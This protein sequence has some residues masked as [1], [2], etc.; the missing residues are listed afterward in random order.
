MSES[1]V[2]RGKRGDSQVSIADVRQ[3][4]TALLV[5]SSKTDAARTLARVIPDGTIAGATYLALVTV[6][7][8]DGTTLE[9]SLQPMFGGGT[10]GAAVTATPATSTAGVATLVE[11]TGL[12][13]AQLDYMTDAV[14]TVGL[15]GATVAFPTGT[16]DIYLL[17]KAVLG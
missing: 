10:L 4:P 14:I 12:S 2:G 1:M 13:D 3:A 5:S 6:G 16:W 9:V 11:I 17:K 15:A 8:L 7:L